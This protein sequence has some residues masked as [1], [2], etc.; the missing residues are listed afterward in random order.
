MHGM[1]PSVLAVAADPLFL[2]GVVIAIG[3]LAS[4][5]WRQRLPALNVAIQLV[6]FIILTAL[7]LGG[8]VVPYRPATV[9]EAGPRRLFAGALEIVWW[10]AAAWLGAGFVRAFVLL[11]RKPHEAKLVQDLLAALIYTVAG[12]AI[13]AYV[14]D[15]PVKGLLATSGVF[16]IVIGLALQ[17]SLGDVFSGIVLNIERPYRVGDWVVLDST[18]EGRV[19]ETNWRSTHIL[20]ASQDLAVIPNSVIAKA[21]LVN[22]SAP[23][24]QHGITLR[25]RLSPTLTPEAGRT[26]LEGALLSSAHLLQTPRPTAS[27]KDISAESMDFD[28]SFFIANLDT[29][30]AAQNEVFDRLYRA[31]TA[32]GASFSPRFAGGADRPSAAEAKKVSVPQRLLAGVSLF[33][34]LTAEEKERLTAQ[35]RRRDYKPGDVVVKEG[36]VMDALCIVSSGV[37][38]ASVQENGQ[39][40]E[41]TRLASGDYFGELGLLTGEPLNGE[42]TALTKVVVY[43]IPKEA[44]APL[45]TARPGMVKELSESLAKRRMA[46]RTVLDRHLHDD[47]HPE[48]LADRFASSIRRLFGSR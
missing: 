14:F 38:V 48:G 44:L 7:L 34:T 20:T 13:A 2:G 39:T 22:R 16:A 47:D 11:G 9:I 45:L 19:V 25:V 36:T 12:F 29:L 26:L 33:A 42:A 43:E 21:R 4:R 41:V 32:V 24:R 31:V 28:L 46:R 3:F 5:Y 35:M 30:D 10:L 37:I 6:T 8:G 15:L 23:S 27:V 17:S 40:F 18:M 1:T